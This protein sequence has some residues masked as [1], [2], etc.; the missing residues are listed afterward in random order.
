MSPTANAPAV[1]LSALPESRLE[2]GTVVTW[3]GRDADDDFLTYTLRY[4]PDG[5]TWHVITLDVAGREDY[6]LASADALPGSTAGVLEI[7]VN[8]GFYTTSDRLTG[9]LVSP[10]PPSVVIHSPRQGQTV[11]IRA[12]LVL[13][14][15]VQDPEEGVIT[16]DAAL[17]WTSSL[18][19]ALGTGTDAVVPPGLLRPGTHTLTLTAIDASGATSSQSVPITV[20]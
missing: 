11:S 3:T 20:E 13:S 1:S 4:S 9:V 15:G 8:D 6:Q 14:A 5:S 10:K 19:G 17:A 18:D 12:P 7:L 16:D 2:A